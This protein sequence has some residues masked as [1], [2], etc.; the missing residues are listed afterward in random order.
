MQTG[1][2]SSIN[3]A[4][5]SQ[6]A[7]EGLAEG[8][9]RQGGAAEQAGSG[10]FVAAEAG[11]DVLGAE[12]RRLYDWHVLH[13]LQQRAGAGVQLGR[14]VLLAD[15]ARLVVRPAAGSRRRWR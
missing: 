10:C 13:Q 8:G 7:L 12:Q 15:V 11:A 2:R 9:Q 5:L 14:G 1:V 4:A 6:Q 3:V